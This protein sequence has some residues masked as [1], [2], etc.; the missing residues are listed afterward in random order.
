MKILMVNKYF[1]IKGG[2][3][4]YFFELKDLLESH[5]HEVIPFAMKH[6]Q[7]AESPYADY[8]VDTIDFNPTRFWDRMKTGA[9]AV[10]RVVYSNHAKKQMERLVRQ[11]RPD[12]A[13]LHMI[14]HQLSPSILPVLKK[15]GIPTVQ[16]VHTYKAV[17][18]NYRFFVMH[19]RQICEK[20]L[21]GGYFHAVLERCH[22]Q[23]VFASGLLSV[24]A[25]VQQTLRLYRN[26]IGLF[27]VPSL[28]MGK[29]MVEGGYPSTQIRYLPHAVRMEDYPIRYDS[30]GYFA[31]Y[32]RLSEEKGIATLIRSMQGIGQSKLKIIGE[33]PERN[34]LEKLVHDLGLKNVEFTGPLN[35]S[36]LRREVSG[37]MF[38]V[39]PSE[40]YENAPMVVYEAFVMGKPVIGSRI[41][42]IPELI[43]HG[44]DG[45]LFEPGDSE[46]LKQAIRMLLN[47][48]NQTSRMGKAARRKAERTI[49]PAVHYKRLMD[50]Y[51]QAKNRRERRA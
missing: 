44:K 6:A 51:E 5:G 10:G 45:L 36:T 18:P 27:I 19:K 8:F 35:G 12:I 29:K 13:H 3:E 1:F 50:I 22:K 34:S 39:V 17:C 24:E 14:D 31:F 41:G 40:W 30:D 48:P 28:F 2:A 21:R 25:V 38:I 33:G 15:A 37:A 26:C 43:E 4:R 23:S 11:A 49:T 47:N 9:Q 46:G 16:T 42:G 7:N 20:C 32:G